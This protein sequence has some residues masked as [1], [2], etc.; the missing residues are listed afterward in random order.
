MW[1]VDYLRANSGEVA[2]QLICQ[3]L[4]PRVFWVSGTYS[5]T[6]DLQSFKT[7]ARR[8]IFQKQ[9]IIFSHVELTVKNYWNKN[10][11]TSAVHLLKQ[12]IETCLKVNLSLYNNFITTLK[13]YPVWK[14]VAT[15]LIVLTKIEAL[16]SSSP[17]PLLLLP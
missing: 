16:N 5:L 9:Y 6:L 14:K 3:Y 4:Y 12:K 8:Y 2:N 13:A 15:T 17:K 10:Y 11:I 1:S 7:R